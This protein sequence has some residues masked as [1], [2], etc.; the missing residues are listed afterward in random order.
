[1]TEETMT[2]EEK[3]AWML[4]WCGENRVV[5][6]LD[7]EVGFGRECVGILT[8]K[9]CY[10]DYESDYGAEVWTPADA[11][12]KHECVA[13]LG[14]GAGPEAQLYDWLKWFDANGYHVETGL[15]SD[16]S[17]LSQIEIIMGKHEYSRMVKGGE[18]YDAE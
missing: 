3:K 6:E 11:Y 10:P 14:H 4:Q 12:H 16:T 15:R 7:G 2:H 17:S 18:D 8:V 5:L 13:V 9:E 1:M